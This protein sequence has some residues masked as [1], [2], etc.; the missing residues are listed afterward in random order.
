[1]CPALPIRHPQVI[2]WSFSDPLHPQFVLEAPHE[3]NTVKFNPNQPH[4]LAGAVGLRFGQRDDGTDTERHRVEIG[5][6]VGVG[7]LRNTEVGIQTN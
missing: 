3:V 5:V 1:M 4:I 2:V 7:V 6:G